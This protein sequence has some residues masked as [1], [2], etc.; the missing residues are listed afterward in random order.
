MGVTD[1]TK[2]HIHNGTAYVR[3][4]RGLSVITINIVFL[5]LD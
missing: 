4:L 1:D 3:V 2:R 5:S